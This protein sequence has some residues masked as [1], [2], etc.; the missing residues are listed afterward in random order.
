V[1]HYEAKLERKRLRLLDRAKTAASGAQ[2]ADTTAR[3]L[4]SFI[5]MGQP[6]LVGHH[7][8]KRHRRDLDRINRGFEK[9]WELSKKAGELNARAENLGKHGV[10]SDDPDAPDKL[11]VKLAG[12]EELHAKM[13]AAN[14]LVKKGDVAALTELMG[15]EKVAAEL[16]K[17]DFC[18]RLGFPAYAISN[19]NANIKRVKDRIAHLERM[20]NTAAIEP[21]GS[22]SRSPRTWTITGS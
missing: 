9:S 1:N 22:G 16:L 15:S 6:I 8:E 13:K 7:S 2:L 17:P 21:K 4:A 10:S 20:A 3:R 5:P 11:A 14:K 18:G 12:L 19:S